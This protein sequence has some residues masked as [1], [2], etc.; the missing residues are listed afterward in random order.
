M[1]ISEILSKSIDVVTENPSILVPYIVPLA[2][3][4]IAMWL[5]I[6]NMVSWGIAR[7]NPLGASPLGF[8]TNFGR[9]LGRLTAFD[10]IMW[11]TILG[12]LA[13]CVALTVVMSNAQLSGRT[14]KV[15]EAFDSV[16]GRLPVFIVAFF[17]SWFFKFVGMF[18]F[19]V[20]IL[21][22]SVLLIFVAQCL[23]LNNKDLFDSF[24]TSYDVAKANWMEILVILFVFLVILVIVRSVPPLCAVVACFLMG[25][26]AIVFTVMYRGR[27]TAVTP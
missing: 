2:L 22:P 19:W 11:V 23:L 12:I 7:F 17:I 25:Y 8:F 26:S 24:S 14:M 1:K 27:R 3:S 20:G 16:A 18:F 21:V 5:G 13:V 9:S 15:G 6:V 4:L 10:W